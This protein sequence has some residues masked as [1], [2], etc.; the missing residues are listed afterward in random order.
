MRS[1]IVDIF[2]YVNGNQVLECNGR[3]ATASNC[4]SMVLSRWGDR[5]KC[6]L[7]G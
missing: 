7:K 3:P 2:V 1:V 5:D 4:N 6:A